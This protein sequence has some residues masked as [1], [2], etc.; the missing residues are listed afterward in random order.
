MAETVTVQKKAKNVLNMNRSIELN[1]EMIKCIAKSSLGDTF[2]F[3][4]LCRCHV[5]IVHG[6]HDD[7]K[8]HCTRVIFYL[9]LSFLCHLLAYLFIL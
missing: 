5:N 9:T 1:T 2:A 7:F 3:C 8:K 6:G 4:N